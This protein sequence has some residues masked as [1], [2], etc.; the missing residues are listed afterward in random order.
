MYGACEGYGR[1]EKCG[2][3]CNGVLEGGHNLRDVDVVE[4]L[5]NDVRLE[6][7]NGRSQTDKYG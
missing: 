7:S 5:L 6:T 4:K 1:K 3:C 2:Q